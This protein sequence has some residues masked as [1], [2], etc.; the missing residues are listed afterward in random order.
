MLTQSVTS[1]NSKDEVN[2]VVNITNKELS[3]YVLPQWQSHGVHCCWSQYESSSWDTHN[4][5]STSFLSF[6]SC[7]G[8]W[9]NL[10][11]TCIPW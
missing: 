2:N 3:W 10:W 9:C 6:Y 4:P 7:N 8:L 5:L 1:L 11:H